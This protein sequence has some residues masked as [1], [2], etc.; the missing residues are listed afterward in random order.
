MG[1]GPTR[2]NVHVT[3]CCGW[4]VS[5][6]SL[7]PSVLAV[8]LRAEVGHSFRK[9]DTIAAR[10]VVATPDTGLVS[11]KKAPRKYAS[12][13]VL[14][15]SYHC[16]VLGVTLVRLGGQNNGSE[17]HVAPEMMTRSREVQGN[18]ASVTSYN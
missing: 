9:Y 7:P 15:Y 14:S 17:T 6:E 16:T 11:E 18:G 10:N 4:S 13:T 3:P 12:P 1:V 2:G 5:G 8:S